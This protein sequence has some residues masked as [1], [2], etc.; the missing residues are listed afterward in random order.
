MITRERVNRQS[1][2]DNVL[3]TLGGGSSAAY[4]S[5]IAEY[6]RYMGFKVTVTNGFSWSL[7]TSEDQLT[8]AMSTCAFAISTSG[9]T[10][11]ELLASGVPTIAVAVDR[12]QL[13]TALAFQDEGAVLCAGLLG[14]LPAE[15]LIGYCT[16]IINNPP[17]AQRL[18][19]RG[20][21]LIDG[22]GLSR[23]LDIVRRQ[24][25]LTEQKKTYTTC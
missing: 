14:N 12:L 23:V 3:V 11:Y 7:S 2:E 4:S 13:R 21:Q 18:A 17:L 16:E 20:Q 22:N 5:M 6:L 15:A 8:E 9:V 25:W 10:L 24:L 19:E 1:I